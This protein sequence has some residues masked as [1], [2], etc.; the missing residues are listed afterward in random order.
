MN[1]E[2]LLKQLFPKQLDYQINGYV[3]K[4]NAETE[5]GPVRILGTVNAAP[6]NQ[7]I[8]IELAGEILQLIQQQN[9]TPVVFIVDTQGQ[10]LS[11]ADE[12]LCL[13]RTFAH[14]ASCVDLLRRSGHA[15]LAI[16]FGQAVSG[17]FL[18]YGLMA[19][20][21][22]ALSD[23]QVKV[24]DLNAMARVT[25]IPVEKL[26]D[27]SQSSAIFAPGVENFYKMGAIN[28]IWP[29]LESDWIS[30]ALLNQQQQLESY[31]TDQRR[32]VGQQRQGRQLCNPVIEKVANA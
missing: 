6:I 12:L 14:L 2:L 20:E 32:V 24:M 7:E 29:D 17:G 19:N 22:Y 11:R 31:I 27:L 21:V 16:I 9:K 18:S 5:A 30:Q 13:N 3:I 23:S 15:N 25:K 1:T 10:D 8:A 28:A 26:K 4:G